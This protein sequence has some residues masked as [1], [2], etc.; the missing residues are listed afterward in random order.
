MSRRQRFFSCYFLVLVVWEKGRIFQQP[1]FKAESL[2][3]NLSSFSSFFASRNR[4]TDCIFL[5]L[6][7]KRVFTKTTLIL[8]K[9]ENN[10]R[11]IN[12]AWKCSRNSQGFLNFIHK[13]RPRFLVVSLIRP[14]KAFLSW[15]RNFWTSFSLKQMEELEK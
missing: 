2:F 8:V 4:I 1:I 14:T 11:K 3:R 5:R 13:L 7:H 9:N 15:V 10:Q 12:G 6:S